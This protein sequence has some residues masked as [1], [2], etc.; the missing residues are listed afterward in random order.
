MQF[1]PKN[2]LQ[3]SVMNGHGTPLIYLG[4]YYWWL[5]KISPEYRYWDIWKKL[6]YS[7]LSISPTLAPKS[8]ASD[9]AT[10]HVACRGTCTSASYLSTKSTLP[11]VALLFCPIY[12]LLFSFHV[13][14]NM[15]NTCMSLYTYGRLSEGPSNC[16]W[17]ALCPFYTA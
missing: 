14:W 4:A 17:G 3:I 8:E 15:R 13:G 9:A 1:L 10:F 12:C 5:A 16:M 6:R 2:R 7:F 11:S